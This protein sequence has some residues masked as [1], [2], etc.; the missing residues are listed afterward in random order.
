MDGEDGGC[1]DRDV[2][3]SVF[4]TGL[5]TLYQDYHQGS[6]FP[7]NPLLSMYCKKYNIVLNKKKNQA[8]FIIIFPF[9]P[10]SNVFPLNLKRVNVSPPNRPLVV[11]GK[12]QRAEIFPLTPQFQFPLLWTKIC[13]SSLGWPTNYHTGH[14][15]QNLPPKKRQRLSNSPTT[16]LKSNF[17]WVGQRFATSNQIFENIF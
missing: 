6:L 8:E 9:L 3:M 1:E 10:S 13:A 11:N 5:P 15:N 14:K 2:V 17:L 4:L 7:P 12:R 16:S